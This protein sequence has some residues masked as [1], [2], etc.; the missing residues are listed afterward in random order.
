MKVSTIYT[1]KSDD[2]EDTHIDVWTPPSFLSKTKEN[3]I[4]LPTDGTDPGS[5][6][7]KVLKENISHLKPIEQVHD[8]TAADDPFKQL[9][10]PFTEKLDTDTTKGQGASNDFPKR[11]TKQIIVP[12]PSLVRIGFNY[13]MST[14]IFLFLWDF[15]YSSFGR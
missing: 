5:F 3:K 4:Q 2:E 6:Q 10:Q 15:F 13:D 9:R 7:T 8:V 11:Q 1:E 12:F 14:A